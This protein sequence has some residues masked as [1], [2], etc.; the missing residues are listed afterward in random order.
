LANGWL[1][2]PN[3]GLIIQWGNIPKDVHSTKFPIGFPNAVFSAVSQCVN[4]NTTLAPNASAI[5][6]LSVSGFNLRWG[7]LGGNAPFAG[8]YTRW[9]AI[10]W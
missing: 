6:D 1:K 8:V 2:D 4:S 7:N 5:Y 10:G 9:I 3:T